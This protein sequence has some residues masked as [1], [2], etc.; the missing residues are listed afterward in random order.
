[1]KVF[2]VI[3][4]GEGAVDQKIPSRISATKRMDVNADAEARSPE[5]PCRAFLS[6][7]S[8]ASQSQP[9]VRDVLEQWAGPRHDVRGEGFGE[10]DDGSGVDRASTGQKTGPESNQSTIEE[11]FLRARHNAATVQDSEDGIVQDSEPEDGNL[12]PMQTWTPTGVAASINNSATNLPPLWRNP[13]LS[14]HDARLIVNRITGWDLHHSLGLPLDQNLNVARVLR[15][16]QQSMSRVFS[17]YDRDIRY[18]C[19]QTLYHRTQAQPVSLRALH[20]RSVGQDIVANTTP[21][22]PVS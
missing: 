10:C 6:R 3:V 9:T 22:R 12:L 5:S 14:R 16:E 7:T 11:G 19:P 17:S 13:S 20:N 18:G 2:G 8:A 4:L 1:V 15:V 21:T